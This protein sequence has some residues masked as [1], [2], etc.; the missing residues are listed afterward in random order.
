MELSEYEVK[1]QRRIEI[2]QQKLETLHIVT[3]SLQS[4]STIQKK[5]KAQKEHVEPVRRSLRQRQMHENAI[6]I[7][8]TETK[9]E[10]GSANP[11]QRVKRKLPELFDS[12]VAHFIGEY[13]TYKGKE[14]PVSSSQ[15]EIQFEEFH[16]KF[17][18]TQMLPKGKQTVMQELCPSGFVAKFSKM[19]GVQPWKNAVTLFVNVDSESRYDNVFHQKDMA[20]GHK[21]V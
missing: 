11:T 5:R 16:L 12:P 2:N 18:G 15:I 6:E 3:I 19:S 9:G 8:E 10:I 21:V 13:P 7:H 20:D 17:M 14:Q 1:R 4:H